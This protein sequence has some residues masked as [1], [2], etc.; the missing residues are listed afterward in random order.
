MNMIKKHEANDR[1]HQIDDAN[2]FLEKH[3][4]NDFNAELEDIPQ[5]LREAGY[6]WA[7]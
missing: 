2:S 4:I 3:N 6:E 1:L 7:E 5:L